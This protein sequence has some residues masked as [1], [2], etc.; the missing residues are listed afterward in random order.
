MNQMDPDL[1]VSAK[2]QSLIDATYRALGY[3]NGSGDLW[4]RDPRTA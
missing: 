3:T 4:A 1:G 2:A